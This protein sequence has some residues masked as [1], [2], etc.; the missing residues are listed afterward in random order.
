MGTL[1]IAEVPE[2]AEDSHLRAGGKGEQVFLR[3]YEAGRL[4]RED[5]VLPE[6]ME[7]VFGPF[8]RRARDRAERRQRR[9]RRVRAFSAP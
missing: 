3:E 7:A 8:H 5:F 6:E 1:V 4:L 9:Q 2:E